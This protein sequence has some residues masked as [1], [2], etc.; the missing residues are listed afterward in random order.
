MK[1]S[2]QRQRLWTIQPHAVWQQ[3]QQTGIYRTEWH[4]VA[5][6]WHGLDWQHAYD[7]MVAQMKA[8]LAPPPTGCVYP[9]WAWYQWDSALK[10]RPDLRSSE[11]SSMA[12]VRLELLLPTVSVLLSDFALWDYPLNWWYLPRSEADD[13]A[14]AARF[15]NDATTKP[16][17]LVPDRRSTMHAAIEES[18]QGIFDL[19]WSDLY[20]SRPHSQKRI[21]ATFWE[22]KLDQVIK[23]T[24]FAARL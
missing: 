13:L 21:Q 19:N 7:W 15:A 4:H 20:I 23:V 14:F 6:N 24:P 3:L 22:L 5:A 1:L 18:W 12:G 8:R 17:T 11:Y 16:N 2:S 9:I 10:R